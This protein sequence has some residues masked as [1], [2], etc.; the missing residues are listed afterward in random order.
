MFLA[1]SSHRRPILGCAGLLLFASACSALDPSASIVR[2]GSEGTAEPADLV[3]CGE[4]FDDFDYRGTDDP[5]LSSRGWYVRTYSGGPGVE[6]AV[7][8]EKNV[9]FAD[10]DGQTLLRLSAAT[11]GTPGG[12]IQAEVGTSERKFSEGTYAAR[13][14]FTDEPA[15]GPDGDTVVQAF[16]T[17]TP[18][19]YD[20]D[21]NYSELDFEYLPNGGWTKDG[22]TLFTTSWNTYHNE[23][24]WGGDRLQDT[25]NASQA[26]WHDLVVQ[27]TDGTARYYL[28]GDRVA[29]HGGRY[30]PVSPMSIVFNQWFVELTGHYGGTSVYEQDVDWVYYVAEESVPPAEVAARVEERRE[31]GVAHT[32]EVDPACGA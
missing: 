18:L 29:E 16:H 23:P 22:P 27:V 26:G 31:L 14:R 10:E 19:E 8:D 4:F 1:V 24:E 2:T 30:Y 20:D 11:N 5:L 7:W 28:D 9:S 21:P 6:G 17:I 3:V 13:V 25:V 32:D 15:S 12:T